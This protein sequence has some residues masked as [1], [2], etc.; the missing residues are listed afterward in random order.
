MFIPRQLGDVP[1]P[2]ADEA[3]SS[4]LVRLAHRHGLLPHSLCHGVWPE[5]QFWTRDIDR[6]VRVG[7]IDAIAL[8]TGLPPNQI[9]QLTLRS[10]MEQLAGQVIQHGICP[11]ILP[12]GV[13][14][15][16]RT[17]FGQRYCPECLADGPRYLRRSW[18]LTYVSVCDKHYCYLR[19]ACP[20]CDAPFIPHR[21][22]SL[23]NATCYECESSLFDA[24]NP[25]VNASIEGFQQYFVHLHSTSGAADEF[26]GWHTLL[27]LMARNDAR[28][29][30]VPGA[31]F[32]WR[33]TERNHLLSASYPFCVDW[34]RAF[35]AWA[36]EH[37]IS[38]AGMNEYRC[39][40][41]WLASAVRL[42]PARYSPY[43]KKR[44]KAARS[45]E[46][47][48]TQRRG[49]RT[50]AKTLTATLLLD[51]AYRLLKINTIKL[52]TPP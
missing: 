22:N 9:A 25:K 40:S 44:R 35:V 19:D 32:L 13:Y 42:L 28:F 39:K 1:A 11:W 50:R 49:T 4:F 30:D 45:K 21:H 37:R 47:A 6:C 12:V 18:R 16:M 52:G 17:S 46:L 23:I 26:S 48:G 14:H 51:A 27:S 29:K 36:E 7:L 15:R 10:F 43:R 2:E 8:R 33:Q 20:R 5:Y 3:L 41:H 34:P 31:W 24:S 38:Q